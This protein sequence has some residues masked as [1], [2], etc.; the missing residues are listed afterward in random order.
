M[1]VYPPRHGSRFLVCF[2]HFSFSLSLC[3]QPYTASIIPD[4]RTKFSD[5]IPVVAEL[6]K[7]VCVETFSI[8]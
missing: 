1:K 5:V 2:E 8:L 7:V 4:L 3:L 6:L